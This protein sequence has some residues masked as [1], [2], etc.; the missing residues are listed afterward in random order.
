MSESEGLVGAGWAPIVD[1]AIKSLR[2]IDPHIHI[3]DIK[4][5]F[6]GLRIYFDT[7]A[8]GRRE[9]MRKIVADAEDVCDKT[10]EY[11]GKP[12][13]KHT[14]GGFWIKTVCEDHIEK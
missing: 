1:Q 5:K 11:C 9:A 8:S 4:E 10:C 6:G 14:Q 7:K 13:K 2:E 3:F 12:G